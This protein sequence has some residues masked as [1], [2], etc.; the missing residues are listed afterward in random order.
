MTTPTFPL[1]PVS[2]ATVVADAFPNGTK[3]VPR[4]MSCDFG[5]EHAILTSLIPA[6]RALAITDANALGSRVHVTMT[7]ALAAIASSIWLTIEGMSILFGPVTVA[8]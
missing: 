8:L 2:L 3:A 5:A 7:S 6:L 4:K 1:P